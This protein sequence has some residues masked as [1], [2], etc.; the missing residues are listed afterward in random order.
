MK[1]CTFL[2]KD[3]TP[4][5]GAV[6]TADGTILDLAA[7]AGEGAAVAPFA[8]MLDLIDAGPAGLAEARALVAAGKGPKVALA[9]TRLLA[10]LPEPRQ[11]RDC[12]VFE[13]H[14]INARARTAER[15]GREP[16][17]I[18]KIWYE[19]PIYYKANRFAVTG[20]DTDV[21]WPSYS[22]LMDYECEMA[23]VIGR[24]GKDIA[25]E[26][27]MEHVFGFT[28]FNDLS[29]RDAQ[30]AEM[31][32]MLG[33]SKGKDFDNANVLGPWIVTMD[34]IGDVHNLKMEARVN[35]E[36]WGGGTSA[37]MQH[38]W[39]AIIAYISRGE[40]IRPGE[41]IGSGTV[42]T[43][44]G[45]ELGRFLKDGDRVELEIENIGVLRTRV[46]APA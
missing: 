15:L 4:A 20:P 46:L 30:A 3:G 29:A 41:V 36:R 11:M 6:D 21:V 18:P 43:G 12:M 8:S 1:L 38:K 9:S 32:V 23:C 13:E 33:P 35:G 22:K 45:L 44:C 27:A 10:P 42:G 24:G 34:E 39:P 40:T 19:R 2:R 28:I 26:K 31:Q 37:K 17:S 14:L 16:A 25:P 7:A 5:V